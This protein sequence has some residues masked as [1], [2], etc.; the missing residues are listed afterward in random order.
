MLPAFGHHVA[1]CCVRLVNPVWHV[2]T[3]SNNVAS[4]WPGLHTS[5]FPYLAHIGKIRHGITCVTATVM[6]PR[7]RNVAEVAYI[8]FCL[9]GCENVLFEFGSERVKP[10][11]LVCLPQIL[12][13]DLDRTRLLAVGVVECENNTVSMRHDFPAKFAGYELDAMS[14]SIGEKLR[15]CKASCR[16]G[17]F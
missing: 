14:Y 6:L 7:L 13:Q 10:S 4:V 8:D 12:I 1:Q 17:L 16:G 2:A 11:P 5:H 3:W 9:K 15:Y